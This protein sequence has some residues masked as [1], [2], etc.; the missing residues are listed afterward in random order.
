MGKLFAWLVPYKSHI[1]AMVGVVAVAGIGASVIAYVHIKSQ[2]ET[3]DAQ[4]ARIDDLV[5]INTGWQVWAGKQ[6]Q[7]RAL[8]QANTQLLQDNLALIQ[9]R[10][11]EQSEQLKKLESSNAEVRELLGQRLPAD[12]R[13]L[14]EQR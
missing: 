12:L 1:F 8:E 9:S 13:S 14:L 11:A 5:E 2:R 7:I 3:I 4:G 6:Q 10:S